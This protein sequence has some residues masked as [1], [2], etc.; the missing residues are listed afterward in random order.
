MFAVLSVNHKVKVDFVRESRGRY[1]G[2]AF[3]A[4]KLLVETP[5]ARGFRSRGETRPAHEQYQDGDGLTVAH[6]PPGRGS[7]LKRQPCG[8]LVSFPLF[9]FAGSILCSL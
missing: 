3:C 4:A 7:L 8:E 6:T 2:P 5:I 9:P 1:G